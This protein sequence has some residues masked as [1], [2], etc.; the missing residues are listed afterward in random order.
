MIILHSTLKVDPNK[1][2]NLLT[3][4]VM[5]SQL[6]GHSSPPPPYVNW[7]LFISLHSTWGGGS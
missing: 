5:T 4:K 7:A 6:L 1:P 3:Q 2:E